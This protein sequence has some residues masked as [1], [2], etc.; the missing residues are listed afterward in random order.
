MVTVLIL[1][2]KPER[3]KMSDNSNRE[4]SRKNDSMQMFPAYVCGTETLATKGSSKVVA[5]AER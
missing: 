5:E 4:M 2:N 1:R 3:Q